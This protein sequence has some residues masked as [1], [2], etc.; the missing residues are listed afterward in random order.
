MNKFTASYAF[1]AVKEVENEDF[2]VILHSQSARSARHI[3]TTKRYAFLVIGNV[4]NF[5][6][7]QESVAV[8][9]YSVD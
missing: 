1:F 3:E 5:Q 9:A 8:R 6:S 7:Q 2:F 4:R